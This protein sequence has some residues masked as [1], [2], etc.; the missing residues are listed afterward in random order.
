MLLQPGFLRGPDSAGA[1]YPSL[2][3]ALHTSSACSIRE[4]TYSRGRLSS[5]PANTLKDSS[6]PPPR[7][8]LAELL[9][10]FEEGSHAAL[11]ELIE[12]ARPRIVKRMRARMP[13]DIAARVG[14]SDI[15]QLSSADLVKLRGRFENRGVGAFH[16]LLDKIADNN[17]MTVIQ[18]E[19][20]LKRAAD[21]EEP[22]GGA[23]LP[24]RAAGA[25]DTTTP[26]RLCAAQEDRLLVTR[27]LDELNAADRMILRLVDY[28]GLAY[29]VVA[30]RL[31]IS[32]NAAYQR[33]SRAMSRLR[34]RMLRSRS[35]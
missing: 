26:S 27:C 33:H 30:E 24:G 16:E 34:E 3:R 9:A 35:S 31:G 21:R 8:A 12:R 7:A 4:L 22:V 32:R 29:Q 25:V 14:G 18:R 19:R 5:A 1:E 6:A 11:G 2:P 23:S 15:L 13:R 10:R 28:D 17:L 20:S